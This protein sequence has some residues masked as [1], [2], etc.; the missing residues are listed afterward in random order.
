M[1]SNSLSDPVPTTPSILFIT[2]NLPTPED[3]AAIWIGKIEAYLTDPLNAFRS[4]GAAVTLRTFQDPTLT[5][6][7]IASTYTHVL[8][9]A[10]D[11][12]IHHMPAFT[13]FLDATLPEA[14][15]LNPRLRI[16]NPAAVVRWNA[17]KTYLAELQAL[18]TAAG[19]HVPRT[20]FLDPATTDAAALA[21]HLAADARV[22]GN[23][24]T[25][26]VLKPS[27]A[28]SGHSTHLLRSP[29]ALTADDVAALESMRTA[30]AATQQQMGAMLLVQEYLPRVAA[31]DGAD[32]NGGEWSMIV[33][34]GRLTHA[35]RKR[36]Q[37][38]E[39]R[40]NS[41]FKGVWE[42]M[43]AEGDAR[44][45]ECGRVVAG[46][47]WEWLVGKEKVLKEER[48]EGGET[49]LLYARVDG[50]VGEDGEFVLM[51]VELIEPWLWLLDQEGHPG[52]EG[53][54]VFVDAVLGDGGL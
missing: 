36:P 35:V 8:F 37:A 29:L 19:F 53:L 32:G 12:Y 51:E 22:A 25:P 18:D 39:F 11:K 44:V 10:V 6:A 30:A 45:P 46:R 13:T 31:R 16:H 42:P 47:V 7:A 49:E 17:N 33:I 4:R 40:I 43:A 26:V 48:G 38:G 9:L 20:A 14:R 3:E 15:R 1:G 2:A 41:A 5:A 28:A 54:K 27:I 34:D 24:S 23:P 52:R 21:A 50:V